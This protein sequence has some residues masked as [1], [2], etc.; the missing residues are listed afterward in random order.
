METQQ[1]TGSGD[2]R[3]YRDE[4]RRWAG[5]IGVVVLF[6]FV[7]IGQ[8]VGKLV[9]YLVRLLNRYAP[10]RVSF[11]VVV[12]LL[13]SLTI[14][15][16]AV[17]LLI[18]LGFMRRWALFSLALFL[19]LASLATGVLSFTRYALVILPLWMVLARILADRPRTAVATIAVLAMFN[20]FLMVAWTLSL[21]I[22]A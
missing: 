20:S 14:A 1:Q 3:G 10:P 8:L 18:A 12:A 15:C 11:V 6:V 7:E 2:A 19:T 17:G 22:A 16:L 9:R 21:R 13:L 4:N 5:I